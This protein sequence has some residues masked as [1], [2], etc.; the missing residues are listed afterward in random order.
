[1]EPA[2][3]IPSLELLLAQEGWVRALARKLVSRESEAEDVA[4]SAIAAALEHPPRSGENAPVLRAWL[5]QVARR[6]VI[7]GQCRG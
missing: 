3:E 4:Q 1:M 5:A 2:H 6:L 7:G